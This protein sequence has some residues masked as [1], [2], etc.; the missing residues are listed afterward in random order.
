LV[1]CTWRASSET[2]VDGGHILRRHTH[3]ITKTNKEKIFFFGSLS[4]V[5]EVEKKQQE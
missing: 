2:G 5:E 1:V 3:K 4:K